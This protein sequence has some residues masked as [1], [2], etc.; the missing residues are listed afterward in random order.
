L[1]ALVGDKKAAI[2]FNGA[3]PHEH[4]GEILSQI[5]V[6]VVPSQWHENNPRVIQEAFASKTPVIASNV[7]GISEFIQHEI[8]GLLFERNDVADLA[9]QLRR[10]ITEPDLLEHLRAGIPRV[11][12]IEEEVEELMEIYGEL[13]NRGPKRSKI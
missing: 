11:K 7:N 6:L 13:I 12:C 8:N 4:L 2:K 5:D 3:F 10:V 1:E 9:H